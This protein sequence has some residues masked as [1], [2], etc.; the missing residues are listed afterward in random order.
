MPTIIAIVIAVIAVAV[1]IGAWFRPA[2]K[3]ETPAAKTYSEQEVA[4]A[5]Q[6][7][8]D[9]FETVQSTLEASS[10]QA[11][12]DPNDVMQKFVLSVNGRLASHAGGEYLYRQI[13][14]NPAAPA[15]LAAAAGEL[16]SAY[17]RA[18]LAQ[19]AQ[20]DKSKLDP[21]YKSA[22]AAASRITETCK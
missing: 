19:I 1:A 3:P 2:P 17:E 18:T 5:K 4:D 15:E 10:N 16:A 8:C 7:I 14:E 13:A 11:P 9:A 21:I 6:K 22:D 20:S 12:P